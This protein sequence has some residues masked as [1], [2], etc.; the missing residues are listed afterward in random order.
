[1][2]PQ[3]RQAQSSASRFAA[4]ALDQDTNDTVS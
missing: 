4:A 3:Q 1:M 2:T